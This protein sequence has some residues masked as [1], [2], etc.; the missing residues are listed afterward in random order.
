VFVLPCLI[1]DD[2]DR[3][4]IPNV[5]VEAAATGVPIVSTHVSGITELVADG[6]TGCL[7]PP[8]DPV[9]LAAAVERL[10]DS[11]DLRARLRTG[12]RARVEARFD[13]RR[14]AV[15]VTREFAPLLQPAARP[16][17]AVPRTV[18]ERTP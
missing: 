15:T 11:P 2:G 14:N 1:A 7:V 4:G 3:D 6:E 8:R 10:L 17:R 18:E 5:L 12:A 9:A 13:L 16:A